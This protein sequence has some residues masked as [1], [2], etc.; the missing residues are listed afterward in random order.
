MNQFKIVCSL[1]VLLT[2]LLVGC[3]QKA[4]GPAE[5]EEAEGTQIA[6]QLPERDMIPEG[7][8]YDPVS[9]TFFLSSMRKSK[10]TKISMDGTIGEF[11]SPRQDGIMSTIGMRVDAKRR[12]I[13][14]NSSSNDLM[15]DYSE[16][17]PNE[18]GVF[19]YDLNTGN[20]IKKYTIPKTTAQHLF[21]D[22]AIARDGS[23]YLTTF[24]YGTICK[25]DSQT[26]E[27]SEFLP[28]PEN[29]YTN[30]IDITPDDKYL[31]VVGNDQIYRISPDT[32]EKLILEL[33]E[34][35]EPGFTDGLYWYNNSLIAIATRMLEGKVNQRILRLYL[36]SELDRIT[37]VEV[38]EEDHPL[39][40]AATTGAIVDNWLYLNA[41]AH[42]TKLDENRQLA[43]WEELS[44]IYV[45]KIKI[46]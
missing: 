24:A 31:F 20:L 8:A 36:S 44:D 3:K 12:I 32:K 7:I 10:V 25:I 28:M 39:F 46:E 19:K 42:F 11:V 17:V 34:G 5:P 33:P 45:L 29:V 30:G 16:E 2:I 15:E 41:T 18:T 26:D 37:Q 43:P 38:L 35:E 4:Q 14:V 40:S 1:L 13:W 9:K 27:L 6:F 22:L 23:V 21:N